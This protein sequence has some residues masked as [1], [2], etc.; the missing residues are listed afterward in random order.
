MTIAEMQKEA[1]RHA[2]EKGFWEGK[3][4]VDHI[5]EA[6]ALMHSELS[7]ALEEFRKMHLDPTHVYLAKDGER[8]GLN[9]PLTEDLLSL[10][11]EGFK[12][13]GLVIE[14]ADTVIR[15][16]DN[17]E[18]LGLNL[19]TAIKIKMAYN[20]TRPYKHGGKRI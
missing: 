16:F 1:H 13:E 12:P 11:E 10:A 8:V 9:V 17:C 3:N 5:P 20:K 4:G 7:E 18:K 15:I 2:V 14:W 6:I 19:E